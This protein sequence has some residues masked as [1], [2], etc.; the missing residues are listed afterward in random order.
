MQSFEVNLMRCCWWVQAIG[1]LTKFVVIIREEGNQMCYQCLVYL[2][3]LYC[4]VIGRIQIPFWGSNFSN[5]S[6]SSLFS[7]RITHLFWQL[8]HGCTK[9]APNS[10]CHKSRL[11]VTLL[12]HF[13]N[14]VIWKN[15]FY[16]VFSFYLDCTTITAF[17]CNVK[18]KLFYLKSD[19]S[20]LFL[21]SRF[22]FFFFFAERSFHS[23]ANIV[24]L[25]E[26]HPII[27]ALA[28]GFTKRR[29]KK[30][31]RFWLN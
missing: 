24:L 4:L 27:I 17:N 13:W 23:T 9:A 12:T 1:W 31:F 30:D 26:S 5:F 22:F 7:L 3:F 10:V 19:V 16:S 11:A 29:K 28:N 15:L 21:C 18:S 6:S 25:Q 20:H 2:C 14:V 8:S